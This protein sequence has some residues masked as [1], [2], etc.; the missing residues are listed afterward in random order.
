[1]SS[2]HCPNAILPGGRYNAIMFRSRV[3]AEIRRLDPLTDHQRIVF[4]T[5]RF[6][7][8]F[9]TTRALELALFRTFCVP[10]V[11]ALLHRTG[12]MERFTQKRYDDTDIIVSE[13]LDYGYE[14]DRGRA[15]LRRM[16]Q[17]HGRFNI[18]YERKHFQHTEASSRVGIATREMFAGWAPAPLRPLVRAGIH[19]LLD[20]PTRQ[21]FGFPTPSPLTRRLTLTAMAARAHLL[22]WFP[23][24]RRPVL[25]TLLRQRSY[26]HGYRIHEIG[27]A[28]M[29]RENVVQ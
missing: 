23:R 5:T 12:E 18:A 24:R 6:D 29:E 11:A 27:P 22:K 17:I 13:L 25:R 15:A 2:I 8:P 7:F 28:Y 10:S 16:N 19:A 3:L 4:L 21:A 20:A 14:S 26:P 1:M 9:D